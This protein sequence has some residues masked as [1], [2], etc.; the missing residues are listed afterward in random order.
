MALVIVSET[1]HLT[2]EQHKRLVTVMVAALKGEGVAHTTV[3][4]Q[5][6]IAHY[7]DGEEIP[8]QDA[9]TP[10]N[11]PTAEVTL[12]TTTPRR[13]RGSKKTDERDMREKSRRNRSE[14]EALKQQLLDLI[15]TKGSITSLEATADLKLRDCSWA[16]ATLRRLFGEMEEEKL[17]TKSGQ[18]RGTRYTAVPDEAPVHA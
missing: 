17:I 5:G 4:F 15:H 1:N 9:T 3:S 14:L 16:P 7:V 13:Q 8:A 18:K 6:E 12:V 2:P 11:T 10:I